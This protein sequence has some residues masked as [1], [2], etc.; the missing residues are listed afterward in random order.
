[1]ESR[2]EKGMN[3]QTVCIKLSGLPGEGTLCGYEYK[4]HTDVD[5]AL[6]S[7]APGVSSIYYV[8]WLSLCMYL[9]INIQKYIVY[10]NGGNSKH[11][12]E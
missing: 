1:M 4:T 10:A 2:R 11:P 6:L 12:L 7:P 5:S 9:F 8:I 3:C